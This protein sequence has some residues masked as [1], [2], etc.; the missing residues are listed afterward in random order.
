MIE[1]FLEKCRH[2]FCGTLDRNAATRKVHPHVQKI[3]TLSGIVADMDFEAACLLVVDLHESNF[4]AFYEFAKSPS[5]YGEFDP[6][7]LRHMMA[8]KVAEDTVWY[9]AARADP[10]AA[11]PRF[12]AFTSRP[13]VR[14]HMDLM[15]AA[16]KAEYQA[17]AAAGLKAAET[18]HLKWNGTTK[19]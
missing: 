3:K 9:Q 6:P 19:G 14:N 2:L 5:T 4:G 16:K 17:R 7:H 11:L 8:A 12:H 15:T 10:K 1:I 13:R 18:S